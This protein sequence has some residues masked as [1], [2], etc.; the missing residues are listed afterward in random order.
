MSGR[1]GKGYHNRDGGNE[2]IDEGIWVERSN[3][4]LKWSLN[5]TGSYPGRED[6]ILPSI[7][8]S[9]TPLASR[10]PGWVDEGHGY[11]DN[12][13]FVVPMGT[14]WWE[15]SRCTKAPGFRSSVSVDVWGWA[16]AHTRLFL[17]NV[18]T[19]HRLLLLLYWPNN[20]LYLLTQP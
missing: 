8:L 1:R 20:I 11:C 10:L 14:Q 19:F 17:W 5:Q 7:P 2:K 18:G 12:R 13:G 3:P 16:H 9:L 6:L 4:L 15:W